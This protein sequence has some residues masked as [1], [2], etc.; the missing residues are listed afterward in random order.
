MTTCLIQI[1][2]QR[3]QIT[4]SELMIRLNYEVHS[5]TMDMHEA[6]RKIRCA[7][8]AQCEEPDDGGEVDNFQNLQLGSSTPLDMTRIFEL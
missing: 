3:P 6:F 1:L 2:E 4:Y 8:R 5:Y 7:S